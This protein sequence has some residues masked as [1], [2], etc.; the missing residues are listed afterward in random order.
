MHPPHR[1]SIS[2]RQPRLS[3]LLLLPVLLTPPAPAQTPTQLTVPTP[4]YDVVSIVPNKS[5]GNSTTWRT[6][7]ASFS[8][9]NITLKMLVC[10]AFDLRADL[11]SGLP[12]WAD[13]ARFDLNAKIVDPDLPTLK[14]VTDKQH[15]AM[16]AQVLADRFQLRT[17]IE[18][19][20]LPVY[21]L[22]VT[23]H[24]PKVKRSAAQDEA[25][26]SWFNNNGE[27]TGSTIRISSFADY[28]ASE[29]HRTV[30]DQTGLTAFY[31]LHLKWA[32][33][34]PASQDDGRNPADDA[35]PSLFSALQ[36]QLG[37]KLVP[38]KGPVTTLVVDRVE[39]P[40]PN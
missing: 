4:V 38:A 21:T 5:E 30:L 22:V 13:S 25:K 26:G 29:L 18:T 11:V 27:F 36:D 6:L 32:A 40:T 35:G 31:D 9:S 8:A 28:L 1:A 14:K 7:D 2:S 39:P 17:H 3:L 12:G 33:D 24:G 34:R 19:K 37:L 16:L 20:Q 23:P 10:D 15:S